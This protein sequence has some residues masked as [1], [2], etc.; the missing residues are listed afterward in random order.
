MNG[1]LQGVQMDQTNLGKY[2]F[3]LE[4]RVLGAKLCQLL[5]G[6]DPYGGQ[7]AGH[8]GPDVLHRR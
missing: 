1:P 2:F 3:Q 8:L 7:L 6:V 4:I 5:R